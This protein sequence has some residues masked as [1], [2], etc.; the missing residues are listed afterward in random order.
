MWLRSSV[1]RGRCL[2]RREDAVLFRRVRMLSQEGRSPDLAR[3]N[4]VQ[5][6]KNA[7]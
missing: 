6:E 1:R 4:A 3:E 5:E 7:V 2:I